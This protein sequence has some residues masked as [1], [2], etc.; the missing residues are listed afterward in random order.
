MEVTQVGFNID[1]RQFGDGRSVILSELTTLLLW[2]EVTRKRVA[3]IHVI[4]QGRGPKGNI[5]CFGP[6][7]RSMEESSASAFGDIFDAGFSFA[8]LVMGI[9]TT[10][11][12]G[13]T[14]S[15]D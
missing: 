13:L 12:D 2:E 4:F 7:M 5:D 14:S 9:D 10:K 3:E 11:G 6:A 8:I 15:L 1:S